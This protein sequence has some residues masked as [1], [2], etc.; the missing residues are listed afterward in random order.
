MSENLEFYSLPHVTALGRR[1][2]I[3]APPGEKEKKYPAHYEVY[4]RLVSGSTFSLMS[5]LTYGKAR[6]AM[7]KF[8][9]EM[10]EEGG[11]TFLT[12]K[13]EC[14]PFEHVARIYVDTQEN[15][16][17]AIIEDSSSASYIIERGTERRCRAALEEIATA[18]MEH[19]NARRA[20]GNAGPT[21]AMVQGG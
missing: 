2:M 9:E 5:K 10:G 4:A 16:Y 21:A 17:V 7:V 11:T 19:M 3:L 15:E 8:A 20:N 6:R 18:I 13:D 1:K 12:L 14:V